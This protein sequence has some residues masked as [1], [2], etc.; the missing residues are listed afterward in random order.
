M[1]IDL[2]PHMINTIKEVLDNKVKNARRHGL[3]SNELRH[4]DPGEWTEH[5]LFWIDSLQGY[6]MQRDR[7]IEAVKKAEAPKVVMVQHANGEQE[8][9]PTFK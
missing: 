5:T 8:K 3:T 2:S 9:D 6:R 1:N 4:D 7:F